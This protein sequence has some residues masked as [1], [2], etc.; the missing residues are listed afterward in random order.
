MPKS[1]RTSSTTPYWENNMGIK[2]AKHSYN[3][4][5]E[6]Y[7]RHTLPNM[8]K[9]QTAYKEYTKLCTHMRNLSWN[10]WINE[11]NNNMNSAEVW[12]KI[13]VAKGTAPRHAL[14]PR[15]RQTHYVTPLHNDAH[16]KTYQ[17]TLST[18]EHKWHQHV[19]V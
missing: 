10:P 19:S 1:S 14:G 16:Q 12:R 4:K 9:V 13:N 11:C 6:E 3:S 15:K 18:N 17:K 7:R 8:E 5:L 2:T